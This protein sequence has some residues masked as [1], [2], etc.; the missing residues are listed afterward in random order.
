M[1]FLDDIDDEK[2]VEDFTKEEFAEF[3]YIYSYL[4]GHMLDNTIDDYDYY[5]ENSY[6][7][8][9]SSY[10]NSLYLGFN[11]VAKL[12]ISND[13]VSTQVTTNEEITITTTKYTYFTKGWNNGE[14][15]IKFP[16]NISDIQINSITT[17]NDNVSISTYSLYE[18]DG[19]YFLKIYTSNEE[20]EYYTITIDCDI[21][22]DPRITNTSDYFELYA[23]DQEA[24]EYAPHYITTDIYDLDEDTNTAEYVNYD[25]V[26]LTM[27]ANNT[28]TTL[29]I[30]TG[31]DEEDG[32]SIAPVVAKTENGRNATITL[33]ITNNYTYDVSDMTILRCYS[34]WK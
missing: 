22:P 27:Q 4:T 6:W 30:A 18:E 20:E 29:Q 19:Y 13:L 32:E 11:S 2:I 25:S 16:S 1:F 10:D 8:S 23:I 3:D 26:L 28:L 24:D 14:F 34:N 31:Y 17:N 21:T 5:D 7:Y 9:N 33:Y 12:S 15:L